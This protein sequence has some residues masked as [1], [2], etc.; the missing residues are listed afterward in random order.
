MKRF[1]NPNSFLWRGFGRV[2]DFFGLSI[3][4]MVC[5]LPVLTLVPACVALYDATSHALVIADDPNCYRRFFRTFRSELKRGILLSALWLGIAILLSF[6]Y[7][8]V[9]QLVPSDLHAVASVIFLA[10]TAIPVCILSWLIP[11][12]SRFVYS[13]GA[14][15]RTAVA[16]VLT[17]LPT[18]VAILAI[19]TASL[20][21][22]FYLPFLVMFLPALT[23]WGQSWFIERVFA[24]CT[25]DAPAP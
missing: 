15:H 21:A 1:F 19:F 3:C 20:L 6:G 25:A 8:L 16:F 13:F 12:Q 2:A 22:H 11:I 4:W 14:L 9:G 24:R 17:Q 10:F 7:Q 18:T 5:C 23:V